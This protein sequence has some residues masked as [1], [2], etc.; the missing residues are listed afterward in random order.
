MQT[1]LTDFE[2]K[3]LKEMKLDKK[4][5][6]GFRRIIPNESGDYLEY[7]ENAR[8]SDLLVAIFTRAGEI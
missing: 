6:G 2:Q 3:L 7:F 4:K 5:A 1:E 8:C